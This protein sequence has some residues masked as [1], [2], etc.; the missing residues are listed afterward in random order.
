MES[1]HVCE[2]PSWRLPDGACGGRP[3]HFLFVL[4]SH[5]QAMG[6]DTVT[7]SILMGSET[8]LSRLYQEVISCSQWPPCELQWRCVVCN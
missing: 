7:K 1:A 4:F 2:T 5:T 6:R 3:L 8:T